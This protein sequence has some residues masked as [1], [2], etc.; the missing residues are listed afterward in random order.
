MAEIQHF[1]RGLILLTHPVGHNK[2]NGTFARG[3]VRYSI[4]CARPVR[5]CSS[6]SRA[7]GMP[8]LAGSVTS[9]DQHGANLR[10][11]PSMPR[12]GRDPSDDSGVMHA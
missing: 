2:V 8:S 11:H 5:T 1:S 9:F 3:S 10:E 6:D 12:T 7:S 4:V